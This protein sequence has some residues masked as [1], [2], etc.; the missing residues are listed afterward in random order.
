M[1]Q[2]LSQ[3]RIVQLDNPFEL[4]SDALVRNLFEKT[5]TLK[6]QGYGPKY[7]KG[8]IPMDTS[9]WV[10][11]HYLLC[12]ETH[13]ELQPVMGFRR[14]TL[15]RC[16][17]HY[18]PFP[19]LAACHEAGCRQHIR[20][21]DQFVS[22]FRD[23]PDRL[24]YTACFTIAPQLRTDRI[25]VEKLCQLLVAQHYFFHE[26]EGNGHE[27]ITAAVVRFQMDT[28]LSTYGFDPLVRPSSDNNWGAMR[29]PHVAGEPIRFMHSRSFN[30]EVREIAATY[31]CLWAARTTLARKPVS[32]PPMPLRE[33]AD[34]VYAAGTGAIVKEVGVSY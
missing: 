29:M 19:P 12:H 13:G 33:L 6:F 2:F 3:C 22:T 16:R 4:W 24:S 27:V 26:E 10:A 15:E 32:D 18:L 23:R 21:I 7:P 5:A 30:H 31:H 1:H 28:L 34:A 20:D 14:V 9:D 17:K 11:T 8:V 25:L